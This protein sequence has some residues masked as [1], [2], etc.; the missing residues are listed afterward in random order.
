MK[1]S[2]AFVLSGG[3]ARGAMQV[4]ALRALLEA[5]YQ[6]DWLIGTSIGAANCAYLALH[7]VSLQ[8]VDE[9]TAVWSDVVAARLMPDNYLWLTVRAL[10][11]RKSQYAIHLKEF[12]IRHGLSPDLRFHDV[13]GVGLLIVAAD[14][15]GG[16]L[17]VYGLNQDDSLLDGLMASTALPPWV[18]P[19]EIEGPDGDQQ[20]LV[21]GGMISNLPIETALSIGASEIIAL[22]VQDPRAMLLDA[23]GFGMYVNKLVSAVQLRQVDLELALARSLGVTVRY[24]HLT[25][26]EPVPLWYFNEWQEL[27]ECGY[28]LTRREIA[29]WQAEK[30]PW[31]KL[32]KS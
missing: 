17:V 24:I 30:K 31:W 27:I 23:Q 29:R 5:G 1:K 21:D 9:L 2:L 25:A 13:K 3:G 19:L 6:P 12:F 7:G 32:S 15:N 14:L 11:R 10:L 26:P 20:L 28:D 16:S 22:D 18:R 4:G 8:S